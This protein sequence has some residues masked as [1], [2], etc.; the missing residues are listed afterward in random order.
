MLAMVLLAILATL[1]PGAAAGYGAVRGVGGS[2]KKCIK[3]VFHKEDQL[4]DG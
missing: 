2:E 3:Y 1:Q 4:P